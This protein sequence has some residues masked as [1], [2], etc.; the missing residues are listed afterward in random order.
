MAMLKSVFF[1]THKL[2]LKVQ[3]VTEMIVGGLG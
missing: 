2:R 3:C 1:K